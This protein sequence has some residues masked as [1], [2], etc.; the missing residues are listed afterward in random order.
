MG[1]VTEKIVVGMSGGVDSSV[2]AALL[3]KD[4]PKVYGLTLWLMAGSGSCCSDGMKDAARICEELGIAHQIV[5]LRQ[6]FKQTIM[7]FV[8]EGYQ[9]GITPLPCSRCNRELKFGLMLAYCR[10]TLGIQKLATGHYAQTHYD[11]VSGRYQ[12]LRAVDR[13]KDQS[14]FL[15]ELSQDQLSGAVFPLGQLTKAETRVLAG[16]LGLS[17]ATKPESM[18]LCLVEAAG[19]MREFL[20]EHLDPAPG[21]IVDTE[22]KVLGRHDGTYHYTIGQRKGL[23]VAAAQ[24]LYVLALDTEHNRVVVGSRPEG[25]SGRCEV[26]AI[27]WVSIAPVTTPITC[28]VQIRY[29]AEPVLCSL[30]P[31]NAQQAILEFAEPQFGITPGQAAVW[32]DGDVLLGGGI[33][34]A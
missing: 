27:N 29:R 1:T 32:Y 13:L 28:A 15:Y 16:N 31:I 23:G 22:G 3:I 33:I 12:L 4:Y 6:A 18:D 20:D 10:Q 11:P 5:D 21:D 24:P 34:T 2:A 25:Y 19:S 17:V 14:Y 7:D 30:I 8:I 9:S 26:K